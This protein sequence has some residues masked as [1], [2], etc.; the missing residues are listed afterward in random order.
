MPRSQPN[1]ARLIARG[2]DCGRHSFPGP[3]TSAPYMILPPYAMR[4]NRTHCVHHKNRNSKRSAEA[5]VAEI[6]SFSDGT[7]IGG[8]ADGLTSEA[9]ARSNKTVIRTKSPRQHDG[10][11]GSEPW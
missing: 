7:W 10:Q 2:R 9:D 4:T 1:T 11:I 5:D 3:L 8:G 6:Q